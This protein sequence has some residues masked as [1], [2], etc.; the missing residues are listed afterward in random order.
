MRITQKMVMNNQAK[1]LSKNLVSAAKS[2]RQIS[3]GKKYEKISDNP[4]EITRALKLRNSMSSIE[5]YETN[6]NNAISENNVAENAILDI[7]TSLHQIRETVYIANHTTSDVG[8]VSARIEVES[9][10]NNIVDN[11][12]A[13]YNGNY[14]FGGTL[15]NTKPFSVVNDVDGNP[16]IVN[17]GNDADIQFEIADGVSVSKNIKGGE[18][19]SFDGGTNT[20]STTLNSIVADLRNSDKTNEDV[21]LANLKSHETNLLTNLT[22][23]GS[24]TER[25]ED[26]LDTQSNVKFN[27]LERISNIE[28][29]DVEE[30]Y[31]EFT[32]SKLAYEASVTAMQ[33]LNEL[34]LISILR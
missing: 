18:L 8:Y 23:V 9:L 3:S 20:L 22:K 5:S 13:S 28:D 6:L 30:A 15:N 32:S 1:L 19:F 21:N 17:S 24:R 25:Y 11:L 31:T 7:N 27:F 33:K 10:V 26:M 29:V 16:T 14:V 12:N 2:S 4:L 34:S